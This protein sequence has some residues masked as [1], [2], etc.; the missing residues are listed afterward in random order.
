MP[1]GRTIQLR[2]S[3][4]EYEAFRLR[5]SEMGLSLS[6]AIRESLLPVPPDAYLE[7]S[8]EGVREPVVSKTDLE[9]MTATSEAQ[10]G[11]EKAS[12][13]DKNDP[14]YRKLVQ[15]YKTQGMDKEIAE[16]LAAR[17]LKGRDDA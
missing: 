16:R 7:S 11:P 2:V 8:S 9:Q 17:K 5:A 15:T 13:A 4:E 3:D 6:E 14:R 10:E 12:E 1:R